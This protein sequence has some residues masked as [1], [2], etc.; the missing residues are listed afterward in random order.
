MAVR[1]CLIKARGFGGSPQE[2]KTRANLVQ[3]SVV[4]TFN[5]TC[6]RIQ[7][8]F[9]HFIQCT[10]VLNLSDWGSKVCRNKTGVRDP[11]QN[12]SLKS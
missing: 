7:C 11:N 8:A 6:T 9:V 2:R 3:G 12:Q 10:I 1:A 5:L 4:Y